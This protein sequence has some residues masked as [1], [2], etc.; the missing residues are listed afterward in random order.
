MSNLF[1]KESFKVNLSNSQK[2][3]LEDLFN[4]LDYLFNIIK[5][6]KPD[7]KDDLSIKLFLLKH[8]NKIDR[9]VFSTTKESAYDLLFYIVRQWVKEN[10]DHPVIHFDEL[11]AIHDCKIIL[12]IPRFGSIHVHDMDLEKLNALSALKNMR[13]S[14]F[15]YIHKNVK[16]GAYYISID[17]FIKKEEE[18][19]Q[20]SNILT[21]QS[22]KKEKSKKIEVIL[23]KKEED[24]QRK[25]IL[26]GVSQEKIESSLEKYKEKI[27]SYSGLPSRRKP[28]KKKIREPVLVSGAMCI[29]PTVSG[30]TPKEDSAAPVPANTIKSLDTHKSTVIF[31]EE[32]N[33]NSVERFIEKN[34][35]YTRE[36]RHDVE[37]FIEK[38]RSYTR[39]VRHDGEDASE[40]LAAYGELRRSAA[41]NMISE[42]DG[43]EIGKFGKPQ[44]KRR[45]GTYGAASKETD[46]FSF[47]RFLR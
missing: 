45:N 35:S 31:T 10:P 12:P 47:M 20:S 43:S 39:Q 41:F 6:D 40:L 14:Q 33:A 34:R 28:K 21:S 29:P 25:R 19:A 22:P 30:T 3:R 26:Y 36:I 42:G 2:S 46:V 24:M 23:S 11:C 16:N 4:G 8:K 27:R 32:E 1:T 13:L 9:L 37:R 5:S 44:S 17:C 18:N 7:F 15:F 38:N